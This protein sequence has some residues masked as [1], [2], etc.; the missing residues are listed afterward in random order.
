ML[1]VIEFDDGAG[2]VLSGGILTSST[3]DTGQMN[4]DHIDV[5]GN[6]YFNR[7]ETGL[8][9]VDTSLTANAHVISATELSYLDGVTNFIQTQIND[10]SDAFNAILATANV[11]TNLNTY[12]YASEWVNTVSGWP[13]TYTSSS[14]GAIYGSAD[15]THA[16]TFLNTNTNNTG[17]IAAF[18]WDKMTGASSI[19]RLM[20]LNNNGDMTLTGQIFSPTIDAI[21]N[22]L[23]TL[24][25]DVIALQG[26]VATKQDII[27]SGNRLNA[28]L[29]ANGTI[30]N[31]MFECLYGTSSNIPLKFDTKQDNINGLNLLDASYVG[32]GAVSNT[33]YG[34][35]DGVTSAIQTQL[36]SKQT[37]VSSGSRLNADLVGTGVVSNTEYNYLDGVTS[38]I[39]TQLNGKQSLLDASNRLNAAYIGGGLVTNTEFNYL[40]GVTSS[41]QGQ[42]NDFGSEIY[43]GVVVYD[44]FRQG[45]VRGL[46]SIDGNLT[47]TWSTLKEYTYLWASK[48]VRL[49]NPGNSYAY[50]GSTCYIYLRGYYTCTVDVDSGAGD[51]RIYGGQPVS[52]N[53]TYLIN[54]NGA[55]IKFVVL[56][57]YWTVMTDN[58]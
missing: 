32:T 5:T 4:T 42:I 58:L 46:T 27:D 47:Y 36:D 20:M 39:Q 12:Q 9:T 35:L 2:G 25:T 40:N 7:L 55:C 21:D 44:R 19:S 34:Y 37:T 10:I 13:F 11:W 23:N 6:A 49:P 33:E 52:L 38:A 28:N 48:D 30:T 15:E 29:I 51:D 14:R 45:S 31:T 26:D 24:D 43:T 56:S 16:L 8:L 3:I 17:S 22:D 50:E 18:V 1:G 57:N 53:Y 54:T 41:I